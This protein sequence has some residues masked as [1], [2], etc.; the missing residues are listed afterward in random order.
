MYVSFYR[1]TVCVSA[2]FANAVRLYITL[3]C[4]IQTTEDVVK[5]LSRPGSPVILVLMTPSADTQFSGNPFSGG[6]KYKR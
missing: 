3:A 5:L 2:V 6:A 4:F 1:A